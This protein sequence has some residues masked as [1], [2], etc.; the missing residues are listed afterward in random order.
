MSFENLSFANNFYLLT[1]SFFQFYSLECRKPWLKS[2]VFWKI[3]TFYTLLFAFYGLFCLFDCRKQFWKFSFFGILFLFCIFCIFC[4][5][6]LLFLV[7][8]FNSTV[9]CLKTLS[10]YQNV[11]IRSGMS[12]CCGVRGRALASHTAVRR[13]ESHGRRL[14]STNW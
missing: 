1:L 10:L 14:S 2:F 12:V 5:F 13:F 6:L 9:E 11:Y 8:L 4:I 3:K 7:W